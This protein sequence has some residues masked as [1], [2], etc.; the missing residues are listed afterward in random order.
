M[1]DKR[2][3]ELPAVSVVADADL[4]ALRQ[5]AATR[6]LTVEQLIDFILAD[7]DLTALITSLAG[8][9]FT[10]PTGTGF[11]HTTAGALDVAAKTNTQTTALLDAM[12]GDSG[13]GGTKGLVPA[14]ASGDAA[15]NKLL[16]AD[17]TW[18][19]P[20]DTFLANEVRG[21]FSSLNS[22]R[23]LKYVSALGRILYTEGVTNGKIIAIDP[24]TDY[25]IGVYT[26]SSKTP[27]CWAYATNSARIWIANGSTDLFSVNP[28]GWTI[29]VSS[30]GFRCDYLY[31]GSVG[32]TLWGF[33]N[34]V[35]KIREYNATTGA[36]IGSDYANAN[37]ISN[38]TEEPAVYV[39]SNDSIYFTDLFGTV[40]RFNCSTHALS[41]L[42]VLHTAA[43]GSGSVILGSDG[44]L[45]FANSGSTDKY[46]IKIVNP[47]TDLV[48]AT[49]DLSA[50]LT[51]ISGLN[52]LYEWRGYLY[53]GCAGASPCG[54]VSVIDMTT[55]VLTASITV[56]SVS[57]NNGMAATPTGSRAYISATTSPGFTSY[58]PI[59]R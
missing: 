38:T 47:A 43:N 18:K 32:G 58:V 56:A 13:S 57:L 4:F 3:D 51:T 16:S 17:G 53:A 59:D 46:K 12:V 2:I 33:D 10:A 52:W 36:Q 45:Y 19:L 35:S 54:I 30:A 50:S 22:G 6:K 40:R 26:S 14:P 41:S 21:V 48:V 29:D 28:S 31:F 39:A 42:G 15:L 24:I 25:P 11:A 27:K 37:L 49:I 1:T 44:L 55:R 7:S 9:G 5:S 34:G 23:G 20:R 8:A